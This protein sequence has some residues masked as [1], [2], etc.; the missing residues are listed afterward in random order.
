MYLNQV[1]HS[2]LEEGKNEIEKQNILTIKNDCIKYNKGT[3]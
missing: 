2:K 3:S 1:T